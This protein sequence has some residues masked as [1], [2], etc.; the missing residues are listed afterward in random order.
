MPPIWDLLVL[1]DFNNTKQ[2]QDLHIIFTN[3]VDKHNVWLWP[4]Q[5]NEMWQCWSEHW[6]ILLHDGLEQ[7]EQLILVKSAAA[8]IGPKCRCNRWY[9]N[10]YLLAQ[11]IYR[12]CIRSSFLSCMLRVAEPLSAANKPC[13]A[14]PHSIKRRKRHKSMLLLQ[15][16][17]RFSSAKLALINLYFD[18]VLPSCI[19]Q[20]QICGRDCMVHLLCRSM[21]YCRPAYGASPPDA[22]DMEGFRQRMSSCFGIP[23]DVSLDYMQ[24]PLIAIMD[25]PHDHR[26]SIH[27]GKELAAHLQKH[28]KEEGAIVQHM[29][30]DEAM[31]AREQAIV[32]S[33]IAILIQ[34]SHRH[35]DCC[36]SGLK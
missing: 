33:K 1:A 2:R 9:Q 21:L 25:R 26:R 20:N 36:R 8:G 29:R 23:G 19:C 12:T 5:I 32:F 35:V 34:V 16:C 10:S 11:S 27:N 22:K 15:A 6:P 24:P 4:P 30:F 18:A 28:F 13:A 14:A 31:T 3:T 17:D 7:Q